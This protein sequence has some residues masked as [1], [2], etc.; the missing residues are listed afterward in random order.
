[1]GKKRFLLYIVIAF[2]S[3][4]LTASFTSC[5]T[6]SHGTKSST[7]YSKKRVRHQ[8]NW[9]YTTSQT[10]TYHIRKHNTRKSRNH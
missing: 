2:F 1:M 4:L 7:S 9:N 6:S 5:A 8:P 10:T 3:V